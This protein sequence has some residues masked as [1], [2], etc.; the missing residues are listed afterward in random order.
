MRSGWADARPWAPALGAFEAAPCD[1][2]ALG[3]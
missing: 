1:G 3:S 2:A